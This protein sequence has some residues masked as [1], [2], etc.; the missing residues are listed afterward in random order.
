MVYLELVK[1]NTDV[2]DSQT[3]LR[4]IESVSKP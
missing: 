1:I 2:D 3:S 4:Y